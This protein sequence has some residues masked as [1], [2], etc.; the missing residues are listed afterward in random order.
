MAI[1]PISAGRA[2]I[3]WSTIDQAFTI[4]NQNFSEIDDAMTEYVLPTATTTVLG[5]VKVDGTTITIADGI[6]SS[7][8]GGTSMSSR[9]ELV[10]ITESLADGATDN[11]TIVGYKGYMLYKIQTSAAAW[12]RVYTDVASRTA[13]LGR[14]ELTDPAPGSG[15]IAEVITTGAEI[16]L[17]S[18]GTLG[19]NNEAVPDTNIQLAVTNKSGITTVIT[20]TLTAVQLEA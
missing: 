2:P 20:V 1:Q 12:V 3:I 4:I 17:I 19:F 9:S 5:G 18:P 6:I 11:L 7:T 10:G 15:V 13:D 16:V 8:G 14:S